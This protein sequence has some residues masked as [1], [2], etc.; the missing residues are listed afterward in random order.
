M[1]LVVCRGCQRHVKQ[2]DAICPF[3]GTP[4]ASQPGL[5]RAVGAAMVVGMG[6]VVGSCGGETFQAPGDDAAID[7]GPIALYGPAPHDAASDTG[8]VKDSGPVDAAADSSPGPDAG[9]DSGTIDSGPVALYGPAPAY[10][11]VPAYA[12]TPL[13][14]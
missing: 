9:K 7:S 6:L 13:P 8:N 12:A 1:A 3:C 14:S 11:P 10:G 5:R 2:S 4:C